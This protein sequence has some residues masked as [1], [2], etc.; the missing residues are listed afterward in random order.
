MFELEIKQ[1]LEDELGLKVLFEMP[2]ENTKQFILL[3][4]L[5]SSKKDYL[6]SSTYAFKSY[7]ETMFKAAEL[8]EKCKSAVEKMIELNS[9]TGIHLNSDYPFTDVATK[10]YRYQAVYDI[11]H[12]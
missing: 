6:K 7:A 11:N 9:V 10:R 2:Q 12:Y 5:G 8:N 3:E 4:K 1:F